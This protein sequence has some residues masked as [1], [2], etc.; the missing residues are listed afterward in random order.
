[1]RAPAATLECSSHPS[2][3]VQRGETVFSGASG[4][5]ARRPTGVSASLA[6]WQI[7]TPFPSLS[8]EQ[9]LKAHPQQ[10]GRVDRVA[11]VKGAL[12]AT[13]QH[14]PT[15]TE[16]VGVFLTYALARMLA[17]QLSILTGKV[18]RAEQAVLASR[19]PEVLW[20]SV[21]NVVDWYR[22]D[23]LPRVGGHELQIAG[24]VLGHIRW[25]TSQHRCR[26]KLN[27]DPFNLRRL[28]NQT[29]SPAGSPIPLHWLWLSGAL[30]AAC[31]ARSSQEPV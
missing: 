4:C 28:L 3:A 11:L 10:V 2:C 13:I 9:L 15:A 19:W 8:S 24:W 27:R 25:G 6:P 5:R 18:T 20:M 26:D 22:Q 23:I 16:V 1:M 12:L 31:A 7:S 21:P 30:T 29:V 17:M 14:W